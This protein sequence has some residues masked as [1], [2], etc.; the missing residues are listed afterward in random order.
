MSAQTPSTNWFGKGQFT[1]A[2]DLAGAL[3]VSTKRMWCHHPWA[4]VGGLDGGRVVRN[5]HRAESGLCVCGRGVQWPSCRRG[6]PVGEGAQLQGL[7]RDSA[8][9][10]L[11]PPPP[12][13]QLLQSI[14]RG[15]SRRSS[16]SRWGSLG[17]SY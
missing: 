10:N 13:G 2:S 15:P 12:P 6:G 9:P 4:S 1:A 8:G 7:S 16:P 3:Q 14:R 17:C 11:T 5:F